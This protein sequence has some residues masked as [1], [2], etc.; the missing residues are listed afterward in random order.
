MTAVPV[1]D[2][3]LDYE[4]KFKKQT[5]PPDSS[6]GRIRDDTPEFNS[7]EF[8]RKYVTYEEKETAIQKLIDA[9]EEKKRAYHRERD[10]V[11]DDMI[12]FIAN[13]RNHQMM[14]QTDVNDL[15]RK[16]LN[17]ST[18]QPMQDG[19]MNPDYRSIFDT[20]SKLV[21]DARDI[22]KKRIKIPGLTGKSE[23]LPGHGDIKRLVSSLAI[24]GNEMTKELT[25]MSST[26]YST[27]T[28]D[29]LRDELIQYVVGSDVYEMGKAGITSVM[30]TGV[31]GRKISDVAKQFGESVLE[32]AKNTEKCDDGQYVYVNGIKIC[33]PFK[34]IFDQETFIN[35]LDAL[36]LSSSADAERKALDQ[37]ENALVPKTS[38]DFYDPNIRKLDEKYKGK[39]RDL[40]QNYVDGLKG[41]M[42]EFSDCSQ[43]NASFAFN[44]T[45]YT[46]KNFTGFGADVSFNRQI[47]KDVDET[48]QRGYNAVKTPQEKQRDELITEY[49]RRTYSRYSGGFPTLDGF[50][51]E[52]DKTLTEMDAIYPPSFSDAFNCLA[53]KDYPEMVKKIQDERK[54][55]DDV[56]RQYE[57][58][59]REE[60]TKIVAE[61]PKISGKRQMKPGDPKFIEIMK[62]MGSD[63]MLQMMF[64]GGNTDEYPV[65]KGDNPKEVSESATPLKMQSMWDDYIKRVL[66]F[67]KE[68]NPNGYNCVFTPPN[69]WVRGND[70]LVTLDP[71]D[72]TSLP[73]MKSETYWV[74]PQNIPNTLFNH[75]ELKSHLKKTAD[76]H[77]RLQKSLVRDYLSLLEMLKILDE[78]RL[79]KPGYGIEKLPPKV[80][81]LIKPVL[82]K[83]VNPLIDGIKDTLRSEANSRTPVRRCLEKVHMETYMRM[84]EDLNYANMESFASLSDDS[85]REIV[86]KKMNL[87]EEQKI[88][89]KIAVECVNQYVD[90]RKKERE[91][92]EREAEESEK[93][94]RERVSE[95]EMPSETSGTP[96]TPSD[97]PEALAE[98]KK[99][100]ELQQTIAKDEAE[101]AKDEALIAKDEAI[102]AKDEAEITELK[103]EDLVSKAEIEK[104]Q[105]DLKTLKQSENVLKIKTRDLAK[106]VD[107]HNKDW[108]SGF[109]LF[110]E[111]ILQEIETNKRQMLKIQKQRENK[112]RQLKLMQV[113][114]LET[115]KQRE[116]ERHNH[117][118]K[119]EK[120]KQTMKRVQEKMREI[121]RQEHERQINRM[122]RQN[123]SEIQKYAQELANLK[124]DHLILQHQLDDQSAHIQNQDSQI[125]QLLKRD[126]PIPITMTRVK[127]PRKHAKH[128]KGKKRTQKK[129]QKV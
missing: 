62:L 94:E 3:Y 107:S 79:R 85:L 65:G 30:G 117:R 60:K 83:V 110:Q 123:Q 114:L 32:E 61:E 87:T 28:L 113:L 15:Y 5:P 38:S 70:Q 67:Y 58:D 4:Q 40:V 90:E 44:S 49:I 64:Y 71:L 129:S 47:K 24:D 124:R 88:N 106:H 50:L 33:I 1:S 68:E 80:Q 101:I 7:F 39:L 16:V 118:I 46:L 35:S 72:E 59:Y 26:D 95:E 25:K 6:S 121:Q 8:K 99:V 51:R 29:D 109:D 43:S 21:R 86:A 34:V 27:F 81:A 53:R 103:A 18:P 91:E 128:R 122:N 36:Y 11:R 66:A 56:Y 108:V 19:S 48:M 10:I 100:E 57:R 31:Q 17:P 120:I 2:D 93:K 74:Q 92:S 126:K 76:I 41:I 112:S 55:V 78:E 45:I 13:L 42:S 89:F 97:L 54:N 111:R 73:S 9:F 20:G 82:K 23:K 37:Y 77:A 127:T 125:Q 14:F 115:E 96:D 22:R 105:G 98:E 84:L 102:I 104:L 116:I 75:I 12:A 119:Q 52:N 63:K 69:K